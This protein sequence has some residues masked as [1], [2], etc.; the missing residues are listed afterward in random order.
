MVPTF[1]RAVFS[2]MSARFITYPRT[3]CVPTALFFLYRKPFLLSF[4]RKDQ[5]LCI[6]A[7]CWLMQVCVCVCVCISVHVCVTKICYCVCKHAGCVCVC[8]CQC[9]Y[10]C[11][12]DMLLGTQARC[13]LMKVCLYACM[14]VCV[15][16]YHMYIP[17]MYVYVY[18]NIDI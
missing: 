6:R 5:W 1:N 8:M 17:I 9:A 3:D 11:K 7:R 10:V 16:I 12:K 15:S 4:W 2:V 18:P 13:W 14:C